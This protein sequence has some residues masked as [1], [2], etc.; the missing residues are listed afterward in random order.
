M[1]NQFF[2]FFSS[3][4]ALAWG[5][6]M[7]GENSNRNLLK[8]NNISHCQ[9][10]LDFGNAVVLLLFKLPYCDRVTLLLSQ[11]GG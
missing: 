10:L 2:L 4:L 6:F 3:S 7:K 5:R 1:F 11:Y 8:I 9:M